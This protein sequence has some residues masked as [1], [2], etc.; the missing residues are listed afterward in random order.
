M[1]RT[2]LYP[3]ATAVFFLAACA[4]DPTRPSTMEMAPALSVESAPSS[5]IVDFNGRG[6]ADFAARVAELGG[7]VL[8]ANA[9]AGFAVVNGLTTEGAAALGRVQGVGAVLEDPQI[10]LAAEPMVGDVEVMDAEATSIA[11]PAGAIRY[12]QQWNM[13]RVGA[14][15]AWAAGNLGS[16]SV[17]IA[18]LDSGID[19]DGYDANGMVDL[20]RSASFVPSDDAFLAQ[21]WPGRHP[22]DDFNGHGSNVASQAASNGTIFAGVT[23]RARLIGVKVLGRTGSGSFGGILAGLAH[24]ADVG[25]DVANMSLGVRG[26]VSKLGSGQFV[27]VTNKAF[28]YA[29][30]QGMVVVVS[31]GNDTIN[32]DVNNHIFSAYCDAPHVICVGATGPTSSGPAVIPGQ[33]PAF[34][35]PWFDEDALT[36]YSNF[37]KNALTV[38]A[39]GGTNRGWVPSVCARHRAF[40]TGNPAAP[41]AFSCNAAPGFFNSVGYAGTSQ[42]APHVAGLAALVVERVGANNPAAVVHAITRG[43]D[44]LGAPGRD[45]IYGR[46]RIN[47]PATLSGL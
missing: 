39:P 2:R 17:S 8:Y 43:A 44:D 29:H 1:T 3:L 26:G 7:S 28:N 25:A 16:S 11:N 9:N 19:Y 33:N 35:G 20:A 30:Q 4:D 13:R 37:G 15:Q 34:E 32:M 22:I 6:P 24:A 31:A 12:R 14:N 18:I 10:Q 46:G 36:A 5:H 23:S 38:T 27:G 47:V 40:A 21:Y 42:A 45:A 41:F